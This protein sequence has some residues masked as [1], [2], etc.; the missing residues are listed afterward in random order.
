MTAPNRFL[1]AAMLSAKG[2]CQDQLDIFKR[3]WPDGVLITR[4]VTARAV[5]LELDLDWFA[6]RFLRAAAWSEYERVTAPAWSEYER[7]RAPALSEYERVRAPAW[8]EYERVT[9]PALADII[10]KY[11]LRT[12]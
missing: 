5:A 9:A 4:A 12:S 1:T 3:E 6:E 10:E 8:S 2:P 7:V 11:G